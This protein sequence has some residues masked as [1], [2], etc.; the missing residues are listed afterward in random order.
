M[1]EGKRVTVRTHLETVHLIMGPNWVVKEGKGGVRLE[2]IDEPRL[3]LRV[4]G[5]AVL[6]YTL[7]LRADLLFVPR[8]VSWC[9][10]TKRGLR[11]I[12]KAKVLCE[13]RKYLEFP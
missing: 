13:L 4:A 1:P 6:G 11:G 3:T 9:L 7:T 10:N 12:P 2:H 5:T 8:E